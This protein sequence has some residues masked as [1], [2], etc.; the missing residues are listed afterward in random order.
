MP[1]QSR[2]PIYVT[3]HRRPDTDTL[4][5]AIAYAELMRR[6]DGADALAIR[7][8]DV[9]PEAAFVLRRFDVPEPPLVTDLRLRVADVMHRHPICTREDATILEVARK[10]RENDIR[11]IP[12]IGDDRQLVG[13]VAVEDLAKVVLEGIDSESLG[14][15]AV[16]VWVVVHALD[17]TLLAGDP[18]QLLR[19][20][21]FI[22][23]S[24]LA[25]ITSRVIP[26]CVIIVGDREDVQRAV[27][28]AGAG[29]L[30][31]TGGVPVSEEV[32]RLARGKGA[33]VISVRRGSFETAR[34]I[35]LTVPVRLIFTRDVH[36]V[37]PDTLVSEARHELAGRVRSLCVVDAEGRLL[38]L[39][40]RSLLL[41]PEPNHVVLVDHS[42]RA[43]SV[44]GID[45]VR[46]EAVIDHHRIGD[47]QTAEPIHFLCEPV[48]CTSTLVAEMYRSAGL[49][50]SPSI[51][52]I[53][54]SAILSDTLLYRSPTCTPRDRAAGDWLAGL[55]G[56]DAVEHGRAMLAAG[57]A[58]GAQ[59]ARDLLLKDFKELSLPTGRYGIGQTITANP[60]LLRGRKAEV[61]EEM[62]RVLQEQ[63]LVSVLLMVTDAVEQS[64]ELWVV[65]DQARVAQAFGSSIRDHALPLP[66]VVSRKRQVVPKLARQG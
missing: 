39:L 26:G 47:L 8:G 51:A 12:V 5:S 13:I 29:A 6:R 32:L 24:S 33:A 22:A 36:T 30:V 63:G 23:G 15:E 43:Q 45:E 60:E 16:S 40:T 37:A 21:V 55:A 4:M 48:G 50:P 18:T 49:E 35:D 17:G 9:P 66:G 61:L 28:E 44:E 19:E 52:G 11:S 7:Q 3:G 53:M 38:G 56:V 65:G 1:D 14:E 34:L 54:L 58:A 10:L 64:S 59:T 57:E 2:R 46:I 27:L 31:V 41:E 42:E 20:R 25:R 62:R